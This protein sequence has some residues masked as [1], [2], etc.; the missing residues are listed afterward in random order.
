MKITAEAPTTSRRSWSPLIQALTASEP[1][2]WLCLPLA[3]V[4]GATITHKQV[5]VHCAARRNALLVRTRV[6]GESLFVHRLEKT[7]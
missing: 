6:E 2:A 7:K 4:P 1:G 3:D 5:N